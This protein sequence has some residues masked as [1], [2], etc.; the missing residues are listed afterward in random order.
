MSSVSCVDLFVQDTFIFC[1]YVFKLLFF[2]QKNLLDVCY[3]A[4][5][6]IE[7]YEFVKSVTRS[8]QFWRQDL[9]C[10]TYSCARILKVIITKLKVIQKKFKARSQTVILYKSVSKKF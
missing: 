10:E 3:S 1:S 7:K 9:S 6:F 5:F 4:D 2:P 8:R